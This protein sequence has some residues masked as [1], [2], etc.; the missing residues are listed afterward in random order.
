MERGYHL[1]PFVYASPFMPPLPI[2]AI[3]LSKMGE[4]GWLRWIQNLLFSYI[5]VIKLFLN[6]CWKLERFFVLIRFQVFC[7]DLLFLF[8]LKTSL[9]L[10]KS[11]PILEQRIIVWHITDRSRIPSK[12]RTMYTAVCCWFNSVLTR[13]AQPRYGT[14]YCNNVLEAFF[15][16]RIY[17]GWLK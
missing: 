13:F 1:P 14:H 4:W 11:F 16:K 7:V 15:S 2:T 3:I 6:S 17:H 8:V 12:I 9:L 5:W 10:R